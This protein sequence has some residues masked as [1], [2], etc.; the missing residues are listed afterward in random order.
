MEKPV[1]IRSPKREYAVLELLAT[2]DVAD[3]YAA[4]S[5]VDGEPKDYLL[6]VSRIAGGDKLLDNERRKLI[7]LLTAAGGTT[8]SRYFPVLAESFPAKD[9]MQRR[10]NVFVRERAAFTLEQVHTQHPQLDGYHLA[11]IFQRMLTALGFIQNQRIVHGA[12]LPPHVLLD[13]ENHTLQL[14]G[15]GHSVAN[16]ETI[17]TISTTYKSWYPK[18]VLGKQSATH[19]TDVYMAAKCIVYLSGGNLITNQMPN[20]VPVPIQR[21]IKSCL[22][23]GQ[24][25]RPDDSWKLIEDFENILHE[26]YGP[27]K[28]Y[29]LTMEK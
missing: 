22:L 18:E 17:K 13:V 23:D 28:F 11:W 26:S 7:D 21:F 20:S 24:K 14:V 27:P 8:Y 5:T 2:G 29:H 16:R 19:G 1:P 9:L 3:I 12:F 4:T 15:W 25:M 10:I 6:K